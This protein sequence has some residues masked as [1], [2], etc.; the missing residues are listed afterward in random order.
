VSYKKA[1]VYLFLFAPIS[2]MGFAQSEKAPFTTPE[3]NQ[4]AAYT[5]A[6]ITRPS[7]GRFV[8]GWNAGTDIVQ[9]SRAGIG[10]SLEFRR[11]VG[12]GFS[13]G[14]LYSRTPTNS[15]LLVPGCPPLIWAISRNEFDVLLT[16]QFKPVISGKIAPYATAGGGA[17]LLDGN[18]A[19]GLDRQVAYVVGGG[20]D[21]KIPL[22][23]R[24]RVGLTTDIL[25]ASTYSDVTYRS[26]WTTMVEPRF[27]FVI[28]LGLPTPR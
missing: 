15:K 27:G 23:M 6:N 24:M 19:S 21:L 17:I 22:G 11:W 4:L 20:S 10:T 13:A 9:A 8:A 18:A 1:V 7:A 14:L 28:P 2:L 26:S 12:R 5:T 3:K 16:R 25:K